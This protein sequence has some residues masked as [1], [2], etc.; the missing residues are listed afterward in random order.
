MYLDYPYNPISNTAY[1]TAYDVNG[2]N[3]QEE[4][5]LKE[6]EDIFL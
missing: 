3:R 6:S 2:F 1:F 4:K 5:R